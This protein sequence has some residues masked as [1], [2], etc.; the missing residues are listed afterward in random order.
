MEEFGLNADIAVVESELRFISSN[1]QGYFAAYKAGFK[2][3]EKTISNVKQDGRIEGYTL[4]G[5][6]LI[7][8]S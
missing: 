2:D 4:F 8:N 1:T 3:M 7:N 6:P 5:P